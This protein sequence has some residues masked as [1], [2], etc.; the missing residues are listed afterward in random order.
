MASEKEFQDSCQL[1]GV[2]GQIV[3]A[4]ASIDS[5][6]HYWNGLQFAERP[7]SPIT[8]DGT[9]VKNIPNGSILEYNGVQHALVDST[10]E[11]EFTY[12]GE[13]EFRITSGVYLPFNGKI[14][15]S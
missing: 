10:L 7:Q 14:S 4:D 2:K 6:V 9:V 5:K 1:M 11:L 8:L 13:Y 12:P 15:I 3:Q